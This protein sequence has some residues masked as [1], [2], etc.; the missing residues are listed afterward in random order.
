MPGI[1]GFMGYVRYLKNRKWKIDAMDRIFRLGTKGLFFLIM[2]MPVL[3]QR[4]MLDSDV[5]FILNSGKYVTEHGIPN[6]EPFSMH[7]GLHFVLEQWLTDIVFW[8]VFEWFGPMGLLTF[9][10]LTGICLFYAYY[11]LCM[12]VSNGNRH[13][14][15]AVTFLVGVI[16]CH[17]FITTRPQILSMLF[18]VAELICLE[19]YA[20]TNKWKWLLPLPILSAVI[21]NVHA[22]LW[23]MLFILL[24]PYLAANLLGRLK[25]F[26]FSKDFSIVPISATGVCSFFAGFCNPYGWEAMSFVFYSYDSKI[27]EFIAEIQPATLKTEYMFF[28]LTALLIVMYSRKK[29]P[30]QYLFLSLGTALMGFWAIR[31]EF[32]FL[33]LGTFPIAR[34]LREWQSVLL[35]RTPET[36]AGAKAIT[37]LLLNIIAVYAL[38]AEFPQGTSEMPLLVKLYFSLMILCFFC[39]LLGCRVDGKI[40]D[41]RVPILRLKGLILPFCLILFTGFACWYP[42][43][44]KDGYGECYRPTLDFLLERESPSD[45][46]M[47]TGF[48]SG[49]YVEYR[50][51]KAYVDARP[52]VFA[53]SNNHKENNIIKEYF[54]TIKGELYYKEVFE[55]YGFTHVMV[56]P[57]DG[58]VYIMLQH[59]PKYRMIFEQKDDKGNVIC[60]LYVPVRGE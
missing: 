55:T 27:H 5:W 39:F 7:E 56:V 9:T 44:V 4:W 3:F 51:I 31:N 43:Q 30:M 17:A 45:I 38:F 18:F 19:K 29:L 40:F 47:W 14:S 42:E 52:E 20:A 23:P 34:G 32:F 12:L 11:R 49:A 21:V 59:D 53:P 1:M 33:M 58:A 54:D 57:A 50:G 22:A 37:F 41:Y 24:L 46:V 10:C 6:T 48:N 25:P 60:R 28:F 15:F 35:E 13:T 2:L 26:T 16:T 8:N 36:K